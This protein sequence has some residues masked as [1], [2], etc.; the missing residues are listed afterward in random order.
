MRIDWKLRLIS[1]QLA[2]CL[3]EAS[4]RG[5]PLRARYIP[6]WEWKLQTESCFLLNQNLFVEY[7]FFNMQRIFS[8]SWSLLMYSFIYIWNRRR[9]EKEHDLDQNNCCF[10]DCNLVDV[11]CCWTVVYLYLNFKLFIALIR[12]SVNLA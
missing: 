1:S 9:N 2:D 7:L 3:W 8:A 12:C 5:N 6:I 4:T 10:I 11:L